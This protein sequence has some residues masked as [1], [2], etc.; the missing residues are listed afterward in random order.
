MI[1]KTGEGL[2]SMEK[3]KKNEKM[4]KKE[5]NE[6]SGKFQ[7]AK[8]NLLLSKLKLHPSTSFQCTY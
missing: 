8:Y 4:K 7:I 5:K 1:P 3:M 2:N 6:K